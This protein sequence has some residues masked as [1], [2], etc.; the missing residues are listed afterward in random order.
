M[1]DQFGRRRVVA[2]PLPEAPTLTPSL[3]AEV[4]AEPWPEPRSVEAPPEAEPLTDAPFTV[5]APD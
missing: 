1:F 4:E 3:E 5:S 2:E